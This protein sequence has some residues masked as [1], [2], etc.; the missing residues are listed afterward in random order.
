MEE[1]KMRVFII[2]ILS[3]FI[4][5]K[6]AEPTYYYNLYDKADSLLIKN[7]YILK[8]DSTVGN[9]YVMDIKGDNYKQSLKVKT[10]S[11]GIL[12]YCDSHYVITHH[13]DSIENERFCYSAPPFIHKQAYWVKKKIYIVDDKPYEVIAY[14]EISG[15][16]TFNSSYYLKNF[17][18]N[19]YYDSDV[20]RYI[21]CDSFKDVNFD[22]RVLQKINTLLINDTTVFER[23]IFAKA[24]SRFKLPR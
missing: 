1:N 18:F 8:I 13:F 5:C 10:D 16:S 6:Q 12:R 23:Y 14:S 4:S 19:C 3:L 2:L 22:L 20:D 17:G 21:L 15:S 24:F 9:E 7:L 11:F